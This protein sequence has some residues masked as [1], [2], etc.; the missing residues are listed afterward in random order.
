VERLVSLSEYLSSNYKL[1][2]LFNVVIVVGLKELSIRKCPL[3]TPDGILT[4]VHFPCL[5]RFDYV[6][7]VYV[8]KSFVF[9]LLSQNP[10]LKLLAVNLLNLVDWRSE[11]L[12][13]IKP[14]R[15]NLV[16]L[17]IYEK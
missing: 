10:S 6:A 17:V 14:P 4:C 8:S 7:P 16:H 11:V 9:T 1:T 5:R 3:V 2:C 12:K 13:E 15:P